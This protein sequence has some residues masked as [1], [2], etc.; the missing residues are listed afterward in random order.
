MFFGLIA[1]L[2]LAIWLNRAILQW[3]V[4]QKLTEIRTDGYPVTLEELNQWYSQPE[5]KNAANLY[6]LVFDK[7]VEWEKKPI[8]EAVAEGRGIE[9][10]GP[11]MMGLMP[12]GMLP[13][14]MGCFQ[15]SDRKKVSDDWHHKNLTLI[16][17]LHCEIEL[18]ELGE[19]LPDVVM[20]AIANYLSDN[21]EVYQLLEEAT[22]IKEY[23][24]SVDF[25]DGYDSK[26]PPLHE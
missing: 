16:P 9:T 17:L 13:P 3:R 15:G 20:T 22:Q 10:P 19:S 12:S 4:G 21:E 6:Q 5:G 26:L 14:G 1:T 25:T 8:P 2:F 23:R 7:F 18:P 24:S 11:G